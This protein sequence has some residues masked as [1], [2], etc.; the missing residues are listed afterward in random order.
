MKLGKRKA[1]KRKKSKGKRITTPLVLQTHATECGAACL[2]SVLGYFGR[3]PSFSELRET[4][5]VSR[6]GSNAGALARA[7]EKYGLDLTGYWLT[8]G[9]IKSLKLPIIVFWEHRHFV[10]LEGWKDGYY[11]LNDPGI[12][13]RKLSAAEFYAGFANIALQVQR[14]SEFEPGGKRR[15][16]RP[17]LEDWFESSRLELTLVLIC[18]LA[19]A[20]LTM[21]PGGV[22]GIFVDQVLINEMPWRETLIAVLLSSVGLSLGV[23]WLKAKWLQRLSIRLSVSASNRIIS[24]F[25]RLSMSYFRYRV[26]GD[27]VSRLRSIDDVVRSLVDFLVTVSL[28]I[29]MSV[30]FFTALLILEPILALIVLA[31]AAINYFLL[32]MV[33]KWR[34]DYSHVWRS[35]KGKLAGT[36]TSML[37]QLELLRSAGAEDTAFSRWSADQAREVSTR[38]QFVEYSHLNGALSALFVGLSTAAILSYGAFQILDGDFT[39]GALLAF[40]IISGLFMLPVSKFA[41]FADHVQELEANLN[42]LDDVIKGHEDPM[43]S[44]YKDG[45]ESDE[46]R[47]TATLDGRLQLTGRIE[48][49]DITFGYD[50][51][52]PPLIENFNLTINPGQR[53]AIVGPSGSGKSTLAYLVSGLYQPWSGEIYFDGRP[54]DEIP[55]EI[56]PRSLSM[57]D[58]GVVLFSG[59]V[60]ENVT[61]WSPVIPEEDVFRAATDAQ[62]H[63]EIIRRPGGYDSRVEEGGKNFSGGQRQR[64]EIARALVTNPTVMVLDEATSA[65]DSATEENI[66]IAMRK[67]GCTCLIVAHRLSTIRDSDEIVVLNKGQVV[68]RGIHDDLMKDQEGLYYRLIHAG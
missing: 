58:Q 2:G 32:R 15:S 39:P 4:C 46:S 7:A 50:A 43:F 52:A 59:S 3:W 21:I 1:P 68:Q 35:E 25:L 8:G 66:D 45:A 64:L 65:L 27:L 61:L 49:R 40:L 29:A 47:G 53:V 41:E 55:F 16:L 18:S 12:G 14:G 11:Y 24:H 60:R 5:E 20:I 19:L 51:G 36:G 67:R 56:F 9:Q 33:M 54:R 22:L 30:I 38:Q 6:D 42:R 13:R 34:N 57:V 37:E 17:Y 10:V 23:G 26:E 62:I 48:L 31:L 63:E 44:R 28:E